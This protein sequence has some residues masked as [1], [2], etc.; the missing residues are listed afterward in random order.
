[1]DDLGLN[2]D[3][4]L[5]D[6]DS[7]GGIVF[8][9]EDF[10]MKT[11][12]GGLSLEDPLCLGTGSTSATPNPGLLLQDEVQEESQA[13]RIR[14]QNRERQQ[15]L[16]ARRRQM[17]A[18]MTQKLDALKN[19]IE[20]KKRENELLQTRQDGLVWTLRVWNGV[21]DLLDWEENE[22]LLSE[23]S[24]QDEDS[25][26]CHSQNLEKN[27]AS[28]STG[29]STEACAE[30]GSLGSFSEEDL[31]KFSKLLDDPM[32]DSIQGGQEARRIVDTTATVLE[33]GEQYI[34]QRNLFIVIDE[35]KK[36][37]QSYIYFQSSTLFKTAK[38][39]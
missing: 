6:S 13:D 38:F 25:P 18:E 33:K 37:A 24:V 28:S 12:H 39:S 29:K 1:M 9:P 19:D 35:S 15:R 5:L 8:D 21:I 22:I 30:R 17:A 34:I 31:A 27:H 14:R 36:L 20:D 4:N 11:I 2:L 10:D 3:D 32:L 26:A 16:R 7:V 23:T